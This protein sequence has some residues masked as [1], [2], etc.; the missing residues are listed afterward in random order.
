MQR[1]FKDDL[2]NNFLSETATVELISVYHHYDGRIQLLFPSW[3]E[4][5]DSI[6]C[7]PDRCTEQQF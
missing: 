4:Q 3:R 2:P 6:A 7:L 5:S 1:F